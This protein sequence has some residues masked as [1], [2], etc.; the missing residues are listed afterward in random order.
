MPWDFGSNPLQRNSGLSHTSLVQGP[1]QPVHVLGQTRGPVAVQPVGDQQHHRALSEHA[2][3]QR[4][5]KLAMASPMR[6]P[7]DQSGTA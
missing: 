7:P 3:A 1:M 2:L 5:L 4:W 6:V